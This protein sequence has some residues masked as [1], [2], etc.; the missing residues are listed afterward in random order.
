MRFSEDRS[1]AKVGFLR[2][3]E[4]PH[5]SRHRLARAANFSVPGT[6]STD[7]FAFSEVLF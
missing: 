5:R 2:I 1:F 6:A 3:G 7:T 4:T